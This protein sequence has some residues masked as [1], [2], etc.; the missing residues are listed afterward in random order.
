MS[1]I[2]H[3]PLLCVGWFGLFVTAMNLIPIGQYDGGHLAYT[4][5]GDAH[6]R[7]SRTAFTGL[8][9]LGLPSVIDTILRE[10]SGYFS[11]T[12]PDQIVPLAQYSWSGWFLWALISFYVVK[13]H[14]PPVYDDTPLDQHRIMVGWITFAIFVLCFSLSP[15]TI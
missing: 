12:Y 8:L 1:E 9:V 5:W 11:D 15:F 7:V 14:H 2:Y 3:Y 6:R 13:L 10:I 4:M